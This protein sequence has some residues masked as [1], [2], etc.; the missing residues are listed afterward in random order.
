A[1]ADVL[2]DYVVA[3][4]EGEGCFATSADD[5][6]R[7]V[8][9]LVGNAVKACAGT[10]TVTAELARDDLRLRLVVRDDGPGMPAGFLPVAFD[11]FTTPDAMRSTTGAGLGLAIVQRIVERAGGRVPLRNTEPGLLASVELPERGD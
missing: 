1:G 5:F 2:I 10:G 8:D 11:R 7:V 6:G 9:N 3:D 4:P